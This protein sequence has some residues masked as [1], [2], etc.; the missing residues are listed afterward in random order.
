MRRGGRTLILIGLLLAV[1]AVALAIFLGQQ[2]PPPKATPTAPPPETTKI[3][4]AVQRS[5]RL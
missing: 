2:K 1:G 4:I 3:V 5:H